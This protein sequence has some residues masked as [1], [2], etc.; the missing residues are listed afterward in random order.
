MLEILLQAPLNLSGEYLNKHKTPAV[1]TL[2]S[3]R[4]LM[5]LVETAPNLGLFRVPQLR[6]SVYSAYE[7]GTLETVCVSR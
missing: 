6:Y 2:G 4:R 7:H 1:W 5:L 3:C